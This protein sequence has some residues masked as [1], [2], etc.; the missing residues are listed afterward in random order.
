MHYG[1]GMYCSS[2]AVKPGQNQ[3]IYRAPNQSICFY[4]R[5]PESHLEGSKT[6]LHNLKKKI[7]SLEDFF[8]C[9]CTKAA[10]FE[11]PGPCFEIS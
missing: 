4:S 3:K 9:L 2:K 5:S 11:K 6:T 1:A 8:F 7:E 10:A